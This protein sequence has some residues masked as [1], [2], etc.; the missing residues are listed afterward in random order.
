VPREAVVDAL[1][2]Q[3]DPGTEAEGDAGKGLMHNI[4]SLLKR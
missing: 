3:Q 1:A 4:K 2:A